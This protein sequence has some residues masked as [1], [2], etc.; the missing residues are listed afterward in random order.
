MLFVKITCLYSVSFALP[1]VPWSITAVTQHL[2]NERQH[3]C[4]KWTI[5]PALF[6]FERIALAWCFYT[7]QVFQSCKC[8]IAEDSKRCLEQARCKGACKSQR[9]E[10]GGK[11]NKWNYRLTIPSSSS[12]FPK[13][14]SYLV[15]LKHL[16]VASTLRHPANLHPEEQLPAEVG[17]V[18]GSRGTVATEEGVFLGGGRTG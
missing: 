6:P 12:L 2:E 15:L 8:R 14:Q 17:E 1:S 18:P 16:Y 3:W 10:G 4:S 7:V 9:G 5:R 13:Q 11:R